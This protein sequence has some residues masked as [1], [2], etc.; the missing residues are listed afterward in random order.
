MK[1]RKVT[2]TQAEKEA[3]DKYLN[4]DP[5]GYFDCGAINCD[6]CPFKEIIEELENV[7]FRF[8][9]MLIEKVEVVKN[10]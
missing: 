9:K 6:N 4:I 10:G 3:V 7:R 1:I 5:C 2:I 8:S